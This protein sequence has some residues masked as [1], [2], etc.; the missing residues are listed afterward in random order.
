[1]QSANDAIC[2]A[3]AEAQRAKDRLDEYARTEKSTRDKIFTEA[4]KIGYDDGHSSVE[5]YEVKG[6]YRNGYQ[7]GHRECLYR[8]RMQAQHYIA[9][10]QSTPA[11]DAVKSYDFSANPRLYSAASE[12]IRYAAPFSLTVKTYGEGGIV[13]DTTPSASGSSPSCL[14]SRRKAGQRSRI[15]QKSCK[16]APRTDPSP[17]L[18]LPKN[19][20]LQSIAFLNFR[21]YTEY[22]ERSARQSD[23]AFSPLRHLP[24]KADSPCR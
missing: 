13:Y 17:V 3:Q 9:H 18:L 1:M 8:C 15:L 12:P 5:E 24:M 20:F 6:A 19:I 23:E 4:Y 21:G 16:K 14:L 22:A 11:F 7:D 2:L 10:F